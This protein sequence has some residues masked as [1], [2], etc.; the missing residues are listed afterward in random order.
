MKDHGSLTVARQPFLIRHFDLIGKG[1]QSLLF[2]LPNFCLK[3]PLSLFLTDDGNHQF[4]SLGIE[5]MNKRI[6]FLVLASLL[7]PANAMAQSAASDNA[8]SSNASAL[9]TRQQQRMDILEQGLKEIRGVVEQ[10]LREIKLKVEQ[11]GS[12]SA[13][14]GTAQVA[15]LNALRN[16]MEKLNDT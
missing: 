5:A 15:D 4:F 11:L 14:A 13:Q 2:F 3:P 1:G 9:L 16:E 6:V 10:D 12:S 8:I 7:L